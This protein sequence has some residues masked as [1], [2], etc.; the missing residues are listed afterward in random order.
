[1]GSLP[2][3]E[4]SWGDL[5]GVSPFSW[6]VAR[7]QRQEAGIYGESPH[8]G[9]FM[10]SLPISVGIDRGNIPGVSATR[11]A[12]CISPDPPKADSSTALTAEGR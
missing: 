9:A 10:G 6:N 12:I 1:M 7:R 2:I 4:H 5:W 11:P 3:L 8:F